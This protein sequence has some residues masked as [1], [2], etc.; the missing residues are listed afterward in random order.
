MLMGLVAQDFDL[1]WNLCQMV[2]QRLVAF[3]TQ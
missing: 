3:V 1:D 2:D